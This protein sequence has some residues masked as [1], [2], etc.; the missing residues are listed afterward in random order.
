MNR[1]KKSKSSLFLMELIIT[2]LL[3]AI[4]GAI[5]MKL[6][7]ASDSLSKKTREL[8][9][10]VACAQG[11]AEVMRGTDGSLEEIVKHYDKSVRTGGNL[12][13]VYYDDG[14]RE[15]P[16][17]EATYAGNVVLNPDGMIQ[18]MEVKIIRLKDFE[19]IYSLTATKYMNKI[20]E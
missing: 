6:F 5:C 18:N 4:C 7:A 2:I 20:K 17:S 16:Y 3:L 1:Y 10:A 15:C 14:F 12:F 9:G 13:E 8:N 11:F 19:E